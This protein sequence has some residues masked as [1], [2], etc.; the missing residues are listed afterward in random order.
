MMIGGK[1]KG[2]VGWGT[3]WGMGI[4]VNLSFPFLAFK[5]RLQFLCETE[6]WGPSPGSLQ[7]THSL[8]GAGQ[9]ELAHLHS[10]SDVPASNP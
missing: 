3:D 9:L 5:P 10:K 1:G 4:P 6:H 8:V 7:F 2:K